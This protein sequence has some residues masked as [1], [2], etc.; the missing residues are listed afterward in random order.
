MLAVRSMPIC[1]MMVRATSA[2]VTFSITW[3]RPRTAMELKTLST[4][5][6]SRAA[7]SPACWA[8]IGLAAEPDNITPSPTPS[9]WMSAFGIACFSAARTPLRSRLTA[10]S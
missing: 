4:L 10:M 6:T 2:T 1:L 7:N 8:S 3:S 9:I 5:P